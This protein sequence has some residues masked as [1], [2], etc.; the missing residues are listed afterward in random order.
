MRAQVILFAILF[1]AGHMLRAQDAGVASV[2]SLKAAARINLPLSRSVDDTVGA[3]KC[4]G[5]GN[6]Y[7]RPASR[8]RGDTDEY[9]VA[10]IRQVTPDGRMSGVF[11]LAD[12]WPEFVGRGIFV[13]SQGAVYQAVIAPGGVYVVAFA[14]D[15]SVRS[16]TKL[17]TGT[18]VDPWH[19]AVFESGRFL[20]SGEAG[21]NLRTPYTAV[22]EADGSLLKQIHEPED[23]DARSKA[24]IGNAEFS[25]E[26]GRGNNF[27]DR[28]DVTL[29]SDGNAY[30]LHG[31]SPA[32]VY[33]ISAAG[34][35]IRK[36]RIG[37]SESGLAF[38]NIKSDAG[39]L[40]ISLARF[41]HTEVH[42]TSLE[43]NSIRSYAIDGNDVEVLSLACYDSR[44]FTFITAASGAGAY[45]L[46]A[47]P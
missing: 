43:G 17:G 9:L 1:G 28:G 27:V 25:H 15:G 45:L 24:E 3:A 12:A 37:A 5:S 8:A 39:R 6:I 11:K 32:L 31:D 42:T 4:D 29:G 26:D 44:G 22:F 16:K 21:K 33:V 14:K 47:T 40:A 36:M 46:K 2:S 10:P 30:L 35:V 41:G 13:G 7:T 38:R 34:E 18:Y 23:E 19:L 20:V